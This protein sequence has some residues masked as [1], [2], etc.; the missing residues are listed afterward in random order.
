MSEPNEK[1]MTQLTRRAIALPGSDVKGVYT[2]EDFLDQL[3][4]KR[5]VKV[6]GEVLVI[7]N[8]SDALEAARASLRSGAEKATVVC[9][10]ADAD[11]AFSLD[12][13]AEA[14]AE[15]VRIVHGWAPTRI[16]KHTDGRTSGAFFKHCDRVFDDTGRFNPKYDSENTMAQYCDTVVLAGH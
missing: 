15:G 12:E 10:G 16:A 8:G 5:I 4:R 2:S 7:G 6:R 14:K 1:D 3:S 13:V 11:M 9:L